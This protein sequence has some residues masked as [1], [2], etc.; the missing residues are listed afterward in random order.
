MAGRDRRSAYAQS[1]VDYASIDPTKLECQLAAIQTGGNLASWLGIHELPGVR[2]ESAYPLEFPGFILGHV[3]ETLGT[4]SLV[5]DL[6]WEQV[7]LKGYRSV[8]WSTIATI[9]NDLITI[10]ALPMTIAMHWAVGDDGWFNDVARRRAIIAGWKDACDFCEA[11]WCGGETPT[12]KDIILSGAYM[13]NGSATGIIMPKRFFIQP[14]NIRVGDRIILLA[15]SGIHDNGLTLMRRVIATKHPQGYSAQLSDGRTFGE[16]LLD[17]TVI[18]VPVMRALQQA[19]VKVHY[20]IHIT[21]HG[22]RKVMRAPQPFTYHIETVPELLPIYQFILEQTGMSEEEA[23]GTF[24][25]GAGFALI[26]SPRNA[27]RVIA[28]AA[29]CGIK[30]WDAGCVLKGRKQVVIQPKGIVLPGK[31]LKVRN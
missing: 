17:P 31:S 14:G 20:A 11:I 27:K 9:V 12:L 6:A 1:G 28:L 23:F 8:A 13:L 21:G 19:G 29:A 25:M 26:I 16:A 18:Y 5:A 4:R 3:E 15:S 7:G 10:G 24:N 22:W 30:A 2:G